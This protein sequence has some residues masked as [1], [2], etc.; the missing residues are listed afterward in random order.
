MTTATTADRTADAVKELAPLI[1]DR[2]D[3]SEQQRHL[4]DDVVQGFRDAGLYRYL[5]PQSLGGAE[6]DPVSYF[7]LIEG[8]GRVDGSSAWCG[9]IGASAAF[10]C[11]YLADEAVAEIWSNPDAIMA[12][13]VWPFLPAAAETGGY[14]VSGQWPYA[15]GCTHAPGAGRI[16]AGLGPE[17]PLLLL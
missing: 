1:R 5:V 8:L 7:Q 11:Q 9:F 3:E 14:R 13:A 6:G 4:S 12:G 10:A 15:S 17:S 16:L 2:A